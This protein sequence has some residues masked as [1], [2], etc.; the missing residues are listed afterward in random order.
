MIRRVLAAT[1]MLAL[2][3]APAGA[4][5]R[6]NFQLRTGADLL[7]LCSVAADDPLHLEAIHMCHGFAVGTFRT[8]MALTAYKGLEPI[9]CPDPP[10]TRDEGVARFVAWG[11]AN[12]QYQG[13]AAVQ[14]LG[15]F[16]LQTFPCAKTKASA[17][18][19]RK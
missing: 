15:R 7:A 10:P 14:F 5:T 12:P 2:M 4:V 19:T 1:V 13:D 9:I 17:G 18:T 3:G 11:K 16:L 6:E 8:I